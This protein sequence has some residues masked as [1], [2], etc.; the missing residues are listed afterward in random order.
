MNFGSKIKKLREDKEFTQKQMAEM[1]GVSKSNV[2]KYEANSVEPNIDILT[3]YSSIFNV[4]IDYLLGISEEVR[5]A[6]PSD[7]EWRY[8][9]VSNRLGTILSNYRKKR[10]LSEMEFAKRLDISL[11]L[12]VG[13]E[14]GRYD[15]TFE[16]LQKI[17]VETQYEMDYLT[18]ALDHT[19]VLTGET[20]DFCGA[21]AAI[22]EFEGNYHFKARFE[23][24][25]L[26][27]SIRQ[28][29]VEKKLGLTL[30]AFNDIRF[31]RM[32]TLPELLRI[33]YAFGV[34]LDYLIGKA[35]VKLSSLKGDEL[36]LILNYRDCLD[37]FKKNIRDRASDLCLESLQERESSVAE[38]EDLKRTG[39]TNSVK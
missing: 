23:E 17:A 25:C 31:N 6:L 20:I 2:S 28:D 9:S 37:N 26:Q 5:P 19:S 21:K 10:K 15:P 3:S 4:S 16:L 11:D 22:S 36:E 18:G 7:A 14:I 33:S 38:D 39:T 1:L 35:D 12:Y 13:I 34:S 32:P 24:L 29:N 27:Q 30:Q 8:P